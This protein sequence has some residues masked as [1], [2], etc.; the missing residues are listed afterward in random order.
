MGTT[1]STIDERV[2]ADI[3]HVIPDTVRILAGHMKAITVTIPINDSQFAT[4]TDFFC[5]FEELRQSKP[6]CLG[7]FSLFYSSLRSKA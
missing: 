6:R 7:L 5:F 4:G 3:S 2:E 1:P